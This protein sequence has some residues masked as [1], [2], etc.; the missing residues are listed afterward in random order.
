MPR[1]IRYRVSGLR[2]DIII[3]TAIDKKNTG[4]KIFLKSAKAT[5][6]SPINIMIIAKAAL[7]PVRYI[8]VTIDDKSKIFNIFFLNFFKSKKVNR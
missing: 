5:V 1:I 3:T 8:V 6:E 7:S 2:K 4:N